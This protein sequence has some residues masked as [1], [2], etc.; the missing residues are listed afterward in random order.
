MNSRRVSSGS[1]FIT[2]TRPAATA[3]ESASAVTGGQPPTDKFAGHGLETWLFPNKSVELHRVRVPFAAFLFGGDMMRFPHNPTA[4]DDDWEDQPGQGFFYKWVLGV[5]V[6][7]LIVIYGVHAVFRRET[8]FS[9]R[10]MTMTLHGMN[11]VSMGTA[12]ISLGLFIHCHSFWGNIY[13]QA[14]FAVLGKILGA[15]GFIIGLVIVLVRAGV[16]GIE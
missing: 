14:W 15:G 13:N 11:A 12:A 6:P 10:G 9:G 16:L 7:L 2:A 3:R 8:D 5:V 1:A 4:Y